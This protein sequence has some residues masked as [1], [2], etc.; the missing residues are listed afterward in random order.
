MVDWTWNRARRVDRPGDV[1]GRSQR[2]AGRRDGA[3]A[4]DEVVK[5]RA[6]LL[7]AG[8][9]VALLG[10]MIVI[11]EPGVPYWGTAYPLLVVI[12]VA[13][14]IGVW[15]R[16]L[17]LR[18]FE[19]VVLIVFVGTL[20]GFLATW[21]L[22]AS[23]LAAS[24]TDVYLVMLWTGV[25]FPLCFLIFGTRRGL[26]IAVG[27]FA[28]FLLLA[29]PPTTG[30]GAFV[31]AAVEATTINLSMAVFFAVMITLLWVLASRLEALASARTSAK[32]LAEMASTDTLT[33]LPNRRQLDDELDRHAARARRHREP[34][35]VFVVDI[36]HFKA[37]NDEHGHQVGDRVLLAFASRLAG[38]VRGGDVVG[39]WGGEEFLV[40][41]PHTDQRAALDLAE[42]CRAEIA[43]T[44]DPDVGE[45]TA[46]FGIAT[47]TE[48]EMPRSLLRRADVA[49]YTAKDNGRNTVVSTPPLTASTDPR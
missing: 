27:V 42:R 43:N 47:L 23:Y 5:R 24:A 46:S 14:F 11:D 21:R 13:L 31:D 17:S 16:W 32:L 6:Y 38:A 33:G 26:Q 25:V 35:S 2:S 29:V 20:F 4:R 18:A 1:G 36:D 41:A 37:V 12:F 39:R 48:G 22:A 44:P 40:I 15:R 49:M 10:A 34:L 7:V 28:V 8:L 9:L 45:L 3:S 30:D 19:A